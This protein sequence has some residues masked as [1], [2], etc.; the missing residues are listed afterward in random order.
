MNIYEMLP[1]DTPVSF[2]KGT[3]GAELEEEGYTFTIV[4]IETP[5]CFTALGVSKA[6]NSR[7]KTIFTSYKALRLGEQMLCID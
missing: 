2:K 4:E 3:Y 1:K 5:T 6:P 7:F